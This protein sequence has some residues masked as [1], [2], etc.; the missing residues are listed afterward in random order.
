MKSSLII[1]AML[2]TCMAAAQNGFKEFKKTMEAYASIKQMNFDV[3]VMAYEK[4]TSAK[5]Q[6]LGKGFVKKQDDFFYSRFAE[7]ELLQHKGKTL[8]INT[9]ARQIDYYEYSTKNMSSN[10]L[11]L[12]FKSLM[13][14]L[15]SRP[16]SN[17]IYEGVKEGLRRFSRK[18]PDET[19]RQT[20]FYID[21]KTNLMTRVVYYYAE[22]Y[23]D[24]EVPFTTVI[25]NYKNTHLTATPQQFFALDKFI[26]KNGAGY[27]GT[28]NYK[29]FKVLTHLPQQKH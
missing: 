18:T 6:L 24:A 3:E 29:G 15:A 28:A 25:I 10:A 5:P 17:F 27:V 1:Y 13:D 11:N 20:D 19:I 4:K 12:D 8:M 9:G 7:N 16:D 22:G 2:F 23:D 14:S 26:Q 21:P